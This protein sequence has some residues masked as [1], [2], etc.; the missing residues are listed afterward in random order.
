V[1]SSP[2][3]P[4]ELRTPLTSILANL[5]LLEAELEGEDAEMVQSGA[6]LVA[7]YARPGRRPAAARPR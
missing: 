6:A 2:T 5:E 1:S 3:R 7:P 4:H